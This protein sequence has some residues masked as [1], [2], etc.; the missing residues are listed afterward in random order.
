[1]DMES[2]T[3]DFNFI[4]RELTHPFEGS[5]ASSGAVGEVA[6]EEASDPVV[7]Y[8][9]AED[10]FSW[11]DTAGDSSVEDSY[12]LEEEVAVGTKFALGWVLVH[13]LEVLHLSIPQYMQS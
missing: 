12:P 10:T 7:L 8:I 6:T 1:M 3:G 2:E 4:M 11:E 5:Y 9:T 13:Q